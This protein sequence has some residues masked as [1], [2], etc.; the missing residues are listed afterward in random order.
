ME[1]GKGHHVDSQLSQISV[2]LAGE[3]EASSDATQG[4]ADQMIQV[5]VGWC[6]QLEGS[7]AYIVERLVVYAI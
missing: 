7:E 2:K 6:G 4:R 5:P 3:S 1:S